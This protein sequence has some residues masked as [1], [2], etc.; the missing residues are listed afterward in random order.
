MSVYKGEQ[1]FD[2]WL[3]LSTQGLLFERP[4]AEKDAALKRLTVLASR[5]IDDIGRDASWADLKGSLKDRASG[6]VAYTPDLIMTAL[7]SA[8]RTRGEAIR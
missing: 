7:E 3:R 4:I 5:V 1:D 6:R 2:S 8:L